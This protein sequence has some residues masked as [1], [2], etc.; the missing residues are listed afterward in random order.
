M[1]RPQRSRGALNFAVTWLGFIVRLVG[2]LGYFLLVARALGPSG[3]GMVASVFALLVVFGAFSGWGSDHVL[4][5]NVTE[6]PE[7]F[8]RY[9]GNALLQLAV[10]LLPLGL[11]VYATQSVVIGMAPLAVALFVVG[12]L[13]FGRLHV[14]ATCCFMAFERGADLLLIN[15]AFSLIRLVA[16]GAAIWFS[17][18]LTI[19]AWAEWYVAGAAVAGL[20]STAYVI[21]RLGK[22][23]WYIA[24]HELAL[25]FQFCLYFTADSAFRESDK[26]MVAYL[27]GPSV[28][29]LYTA[30]FRIVD[31]AA[32]PLR[33]M[34]AAFYAR[35]FKHGHKGIEHSFQ[36]A[37]KVLP[38]TLGYSAF[39][40]IVL[41]FGADYLPLV[42]GDKFRAAAPVTVWLA[43][44]PLFNGLTAIGGD[45]LTSAGKQRAR[46]VV[47]SALSLL[48]VLLAS[49]LVPRFGA[50]GAAY[51]ALGNAVLV[52]ATMWLM[53]FRARR[54]AARAT[55]AAAPA[56]QAEPRS[57]VRL[58]A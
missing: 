4:I 58:A 41:S 40:G 19:A 37:L 12:D 49:L 57:A 22:P 20:L 51:A 17:R 25:G 18:P 46:A 10:T 23:R 21:A 2:Q 39:A 45:I 55:P 15:I 38:L 7:R 50:A 43:F 8:G 9:F 24:R 53:V 14:L 29:G 27:A 13:F 16:C 3:Y 5:R 33:A 31:A 36:F 6:A 30:A 34:T 35:F 42:L 28:A 11:L 32:M 48:P 1:A 47:I 44:L 26:P 54:H 56:P 52:A